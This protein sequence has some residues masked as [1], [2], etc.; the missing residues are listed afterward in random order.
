MLPLKSRDGHELEAYLAQP[1]GPAR[2]GLV[3]AQEMYG[4]NGYLRAVCDFYAS[5]GYLAIAPA[6]YDRIRRGLV[7]SYDQEDHDRAQ[8]LYKAWDWDVVLDDLDAGRDAV[9][10]AG[11]VGMVGFCAGGS[12]AWLA[13]CRRS[14]A[15]TIAYYGS[16]MPDCAGETAHCPVIAHIGDSDN[17]LPPA[18]ID[19]FRA[20][21]PDVPI[22][23]Y[24]GAQHG[25][26]NE[27]RTARYHADACKLART[28]SLEFL[29]RHVG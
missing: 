8:K 23:L 24:P 12:L 26:D 28:R 7:L 1:A 25:F 20:A 27:N 21:Q 6:L 11:K 13:A 17:T 22:H 4:V 18:R 9:S 3:V 19:I 14:Y 15:C 16:T 10:Q 5:H 29:A 2:G